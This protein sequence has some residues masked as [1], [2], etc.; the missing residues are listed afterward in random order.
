MRGGKGRGPVEVAV[1]AEGGVVGC[2]GGGGGGRGGGGGGVLHGVHGDVAEWRRGGERLVR[3]GRWEG[4]KGKEMEMDGWVGRHT[5][6][7]VPPENSSS[8]PV[9]HLMASSDPGLPPPPPPPPKI[10]TTAHVTSAPTG[11]AR[12]KMTRWALALRLP[13]PCWRR[14]EVRPK[15]AGALWIMMAR[16]MMKE[17][18]GVVEEEAPRAM[19]SAAAWMQRP[20]VVERVRGGVEAGEVVMVGA[21]ER[22]ERE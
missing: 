17:R 8:T 11:A 18:E 19:P 21:E 22:S 6:R 4:T 15:A 14:T 13:R 3:G 7:N 1:A 20:R 12:L 5:Y 10:L 9:H 16:K 2:G